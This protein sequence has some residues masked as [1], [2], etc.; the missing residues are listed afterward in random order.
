[1]NT[2]PL[3]EKVAVIGLGYVGLPLALEFSKHIPVVGYDVSEKLLS[4]LV[5]NHS[6]TG[7]KFTKEPQD[8]AESTVFIICVPTP[9]REDGKPDLSYVKSATSTISKLL[10]KGDMV[11]LEST[12]YP[13][14]TREIL[15]PMLEESRLKVNKDFHLVFSPERIDPGNPS[16]EV[17]NITKLVGG[18]DEAAL[19]R[20]VSNRS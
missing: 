2:D 14:T 1:M 15:K 19:N 4:K 20:A 7:I 17:N 6:E 16:F 11:I 18:M 10:K 3:N 9:L 5:Q 8:M 13:G 12:T